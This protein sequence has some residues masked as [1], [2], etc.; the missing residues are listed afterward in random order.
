MTNTLRSAQQKLYIA[1]R[2]YKCII[3]IILLLHFVYMKDNFL[4]RDDH[5]EKLNQNK[6][7]AQY[8]C[9][10]FYYIPFYATMKKL[11]KH[12]VVSENTCS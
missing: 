7:L 3:I 4:S 11:P 9:V 12:L 8:L 2:Y 6:M 1:T 5:D 10:V